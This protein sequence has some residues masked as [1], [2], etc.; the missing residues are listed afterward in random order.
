MTIA[1]ILWG[2][3]LSGYLFYRI[4]MIGEDKRFDG[5]RE[6]CLKFLGFWVFQMMWVW[7]VSLPVTFVNGDDADPPLNASDYAVL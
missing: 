5:M 4:L 2:L 7:I 3:R 6:N 1:V